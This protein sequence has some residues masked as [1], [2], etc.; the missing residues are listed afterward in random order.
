ML[1]I[2]N[3][4]MLNKPSVQHVAASIRLKPFGQTVPLALS[5]VDS[6]RVAVAPFSVLVDVSV[7]DVTVVVRGGD[8]KWVC[9][10]FHELA[11]AFLSL[12]KQ[13]PSLC[14]RT[15]FDISHAVGI[16][17]SG[18]RAINRYWRVSLNGKATIMKSVRFAFA[19]FIDLATILSLPFECCDCS[20]NH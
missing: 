3:R 5:S 19:V 8:L 18:M 6:R 4:E 20:D 15:P 10:Y 1:N 11:R 17:S 16:R 7:S 9:N 13:I 2:E 14:L 12:R